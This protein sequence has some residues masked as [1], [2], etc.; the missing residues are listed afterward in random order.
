MV[1]RMDP[2][3]RAPTIQPAT[4]AIAA[5]TAAAVDELDQASHPSRR[6]RSTTRNITTGVTPAIAPRR[7]AAEVRRRSMMFERTSVVMSSPKLL[8]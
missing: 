8:L 1:S 3:L 4:T 7:P 6:S 5:M 2:L